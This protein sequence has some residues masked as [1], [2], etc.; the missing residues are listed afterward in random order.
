MGD[1]S[2]I[3]IKQHDGNRV[4]LYGHWMGADSINVVRD[5]LAHRERWSDAPYLARMLFNRMTLGQEQGDTGYGIST[6]MCDNE[7][8]VIVLDPETQTVV[9]ED[10]PWGEPLVPITPAV[11]FKTF[12]TCGRETNPT[13]ADVAVDM[14]AKL[15]FA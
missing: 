14:G 6:Y 2:N 5:T 10:A 7:Y 8:P 12:I 4:W 13:F 1:R 3:V 9:L 11:S 15:S